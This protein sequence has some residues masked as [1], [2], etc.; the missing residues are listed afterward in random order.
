MPTEQQ[1]VHQLF[2][3]A[4][5]H[6][7]IQCGKAGCAGPVETLDLSQTRDRVK[8]FDAHCERC[9]WQMRIGG[10]E[11][12][13]PPWDD[14]SLLMMADEHLMHQQP[15]CPFDDT[16]VVFISM[17]NPR[18]KAKYRVACFYCGRQIEMDWPP[19]EAKR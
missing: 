19:A 12:V 13:T 5:Q 6:E 11:Q 8:T 2:I 17:P 14:A 18:R 4:L 16:P 3:K 9:G 7:P 10:K 1:R 15:V